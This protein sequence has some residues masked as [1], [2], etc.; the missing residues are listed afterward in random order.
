MQNGL[1][2]VLCFVIS[3]V[4]VWGVQAT[5]SNSMDVNVAVTNPS[6]IS[7]IQKLKVGDREQAEKHL[8]HE[9]NHSVFL[10]PT[11]VDS[12]KNLQSTSGNKI[13]IA[14][15]SDSKGN[16]YL[17]VFSDWDALH[18]FSERPLNGLVFPAKDVWSLFLSTESYEG[19]V[20]NPGSDSIVLSK[21]QIE[22][23]VGN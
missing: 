9:L 2:V 22:L 21:D 19:I 5:E 10:I 15:T 6:L 18:S 1:R 8:L 11:L 13:S 23:L 12:P 7:A 20:V 14:L 3:F 4:I 16:I 17:P